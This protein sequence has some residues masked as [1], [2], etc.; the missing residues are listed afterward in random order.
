MRRLTTTSSVSDDVNGTQKSPSFAV[1]RVLSVKVCV[2]P[3]LMSGTVYSSSFA[4]PHK[5]FVL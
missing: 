3:I 2:C 1:C 5:D 4:C